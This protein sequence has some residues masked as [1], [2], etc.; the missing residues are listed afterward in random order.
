MEM[1]NSRVFFVKEVK[2]ARKTL[3]GNAQ[4]LWLITPTNDFHVH[5]SLC[6]LENGTET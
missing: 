3:A 2:L 1:G 4:L 6:S 5:P